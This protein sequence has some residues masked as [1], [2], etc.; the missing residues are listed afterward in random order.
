MT[1]QDKLFLTRLQL[2]QLQSDTPYIDDWYYVM[3][4]ERRSRSADG[5]AASDENSAADPLED[6]RALRSLSHQLELR[7]AQNA[8]LYVK[9]RRDF[10]GVTV[11]GSLGALQRGSNM[12]PRQLLQMHGGEKE[13]EDDEAGEDEAEEKKKS[14]EMAAKDASPVMAAAAAQQQ[15]HQQAELFKARA[16]L[17]AVEKIYQ[18]IIQFE[19][20]RVNELTG[21][22]VSLNP[23]PYVSGK[24][25]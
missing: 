2:S 15:Q 6:L 9:Q 11:Q 23:D 12:R 24:G 21:V 25:E 3:V 13:K 8:K 4:T 16:T 20:A 19:D 10:A 18:L 5:S 7:E 14:P 17:V 1:E 22:V